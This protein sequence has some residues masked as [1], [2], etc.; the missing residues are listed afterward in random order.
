[1]SKLGAAI[2]LWGPLLAASLAL[3]AP[4][5]AQIGPGGLG[6]PSGTLPTPQPPGQGGKPGP[7]GPKTHAA[8]GGDIFKTQ[9]ALGHA[10]PTTTVL[11]LYTFQEEID[12][13]VLAI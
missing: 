8:S 4:A 3:S 10:L 5:A 6:D 9:K 11:Y 12:A 7:E 13:L 1:M 2:R